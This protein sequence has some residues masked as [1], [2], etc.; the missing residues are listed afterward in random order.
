V[1][2][3]GQNDQTNWVTSQRNNSNN[4]QLVAVTAFGELTN[5]FSEFIMLVDISQKGP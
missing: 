5:N 1:V 2:D 4:S 3:W